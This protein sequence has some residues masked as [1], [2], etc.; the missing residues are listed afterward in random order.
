M[1]N[2]TPALLLL[3]NA[4]RALVLV[5]IG[6]L[7]SVAFAQDTPVDDDDPAAADADE[8]LADDAE[9]GESTLDGGL[10][11]EEE[12]ERDEDSLAAPPEPVEPT[13]QSSAATPTA[14]DSIVRGFFVEARVGGGYALTSADIPEDPVF[15]TLE[16]QSEELGA[17]SQIGFHIGYDVT[18]VI[19]LEA[20]SGA[21]FIG[22]RRDDRVRDLSLFYGG[23]GVKLSFELER[24]LRL[25][26]GAAALFVQSDNGVEDS[27]TG[28][29]VLGSAG[30]EYYVHVRHLS[31]GFD[32]TALAPFS[33]SR[34]FIGLTPRLKYTF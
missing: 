2:A 5:S 30:L 13:V 20:V 28:A 21:T 22:G 7:S 16:G 14:L 32:V 3:K 9:S 10:S 4:C 8:P 6:S 17:G 1:L 29:G 12:N 24:R 23:A 34:I 27:E 18:E 19:A 11:G 25:G 15:P 33:P 26:L 31:V